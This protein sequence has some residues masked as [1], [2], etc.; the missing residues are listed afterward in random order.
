[1]REL[2]IQKKE[3]NIRRYLEGLVPERFIG[4]ENV[5]KRDELIN[6]ILNDTTIDHVG[7]VK[8][9]GNHLKFDSIEKLSEFKKEKTNKK[10]S[11]DDC[12][13]ISS[14]IYTLNG[15]RNMDVE[16]I[17]VETQYYKDA[18][19]IDYEIVGNDK[20]YWQSESEM[21]AR[22]FACYVADKAYEKGIICDYLTGH[23]DSI[24]IPQGEKVVR[25]FPVGDERKEINKAFDVLINKYKELDLLKEKTA[26]FK[27]EKA[28]EKEQL[29]LFDKVQVAEKRR[30][31][32]VSTTK[33]GSSGRNE[34]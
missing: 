17:R 27:L 29:T 20:G 7:Y 31:P 30:V 11:L 16:K 26:E 15:K 9:F 19:T 14:Y 22:A 13:T 2:E 24:A 5:P 33:D 8:M 18:K 6:D 25:A 21:F 23:A 10:I 32:L 34:R 12:K 4:T 1:M 28:V 3:A